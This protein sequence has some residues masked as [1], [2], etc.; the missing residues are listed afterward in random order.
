MVKCSLPKEAHYKTSKTKDLYICIN[1]GYEKEYVHGDK[2][3]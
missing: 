3:R 1:C 2:F